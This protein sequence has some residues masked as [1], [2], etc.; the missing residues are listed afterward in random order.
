M[1]AGKF[2]FAAAATFVAV[3][4]PGPLTY[5]LVYMTLFLIPEPLEIGTRG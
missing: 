4:F 1:T 3:L 2:G 5:L